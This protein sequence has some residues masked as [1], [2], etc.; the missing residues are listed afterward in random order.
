MKILSRLLKKHLNWNL[1]VVS[2]SETDVDIISVYGAVEST[3]I[4][5]CSL[6]KVL[7]DFGE[8]RSV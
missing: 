7:E 1:T 2:G 3:E 5:K 6:G 8:Q 4:A